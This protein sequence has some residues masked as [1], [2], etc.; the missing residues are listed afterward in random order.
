[1]TTRARA[2]HLK[3]QKRHLL[4]KRQ[5]KAPCAAAFEIN[6][7]KSVIPW[8]ARSLVVAA[9]WELGLHR[10][11]D[12]LFVLNWFSWQIVSNDDPNNYSLVVYCEKA[13]CP[14]TKTLFD[15]LPSSKHKR[16]YYLLWRSAFKFGI[17]K[18]SISPSVLLLLKYFPKYA[19]A[20][21][22]FPRLLTLALT[23]SCLQHIRWV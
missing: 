15:A 16:G 13:P 20:S 11:T 17:C 6:F 14:F 2:I 9:G 18:W 7:Q 5:I 4:C 22:V 19:A 12:S 1:M 3:H 8:V 23:T 10:V 21:E